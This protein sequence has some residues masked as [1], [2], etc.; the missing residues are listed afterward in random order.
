[1]NTAVP[2]RG[3]SQ[4]EVFKSIAQPEETNF[5]M[6]KATE[7]IGCCIVSPAGQAAKTEL[8]KF[9]VVE[10]FTWEKKVFRFQGNCLILATKLLFLRQFFSVGIPVKMK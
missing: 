8:K 6:C 9:W 7:E 2:N 5:Y 1:M 4:E 3:I 10:I